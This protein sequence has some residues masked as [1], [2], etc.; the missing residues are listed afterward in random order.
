MI[1]RPGNEH[2]LQKIVAEECKAYSE[3]LEISAGTSQS[4]AEDSQSD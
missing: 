1:K 3:A 2:Y 4:E